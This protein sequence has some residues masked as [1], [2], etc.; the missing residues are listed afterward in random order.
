[1]REKDRKNVDFEKEQ[2]GRERTVMRVRVR[3]EN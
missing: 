1:M 2:N 3:L